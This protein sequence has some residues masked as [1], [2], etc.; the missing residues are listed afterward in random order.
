MTHMP[1]QPYVNFPWEAWRI[2][3]EEL[4]FSKSQ[5]RRVEPTL[6]AIRKTSGLMSLDETMRQLVVLSWMTLLEEPEPRLNPEDYDRTGE[7]V[8]P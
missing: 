1:P 4:A 8:M 3:L 5:R 2:A 6:S 7:V